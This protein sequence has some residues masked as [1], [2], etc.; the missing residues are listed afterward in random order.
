V[1]GDWG[2]FGYAMK[3]AT[4]DFGPHDVS[5]ILFD[6]YG[7]FGLNEYFVLILEATS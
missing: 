5:V 3:E 6:L 7:W 4:T 2:K 1:W